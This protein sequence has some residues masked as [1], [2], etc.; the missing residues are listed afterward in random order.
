MLSALLLAL[1]GSAHA[2][3]FGSYFANWAKYHAGNY[4]YDASA[5][6]PLAPAL[7][8]INYA[9]FYLCPPPGTNPLPYWA[10][11]PYGAS[12]SH[13]PATE[14][15]PTHPSCCHGAPTAC[16]APLTFTHPHAHPRLHPQAPA[17]TPR[18]TSS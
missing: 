10:Q 2:T 4:A 13:T 11:P 6:A 18:P 1:A 15:P 17:R 3:E 8:E 7:Q 16:T 5:M 9:F 14:Q 12:H